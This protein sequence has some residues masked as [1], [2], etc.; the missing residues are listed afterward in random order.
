MFNIIYKIF[1]F[2]NIILYYIYIT[3]IILIIKVIA[4]VLLIVFIYT[5]SNCETLKVFKSLDSKITAA[6]NI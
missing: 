3:N 1:F 4:L 2:K 6:L 5:S